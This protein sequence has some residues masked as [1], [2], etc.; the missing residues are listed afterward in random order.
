MGRCS[1]TDRHGSSQL[2]GTLQ[3]VGGDL[4]RLDDVLRQ[5]DRRHRRRTDG[6]V[7]RARAG[8]G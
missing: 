1:R 5:P 6:P 4:E 8:D 3:E 2:G 7:G